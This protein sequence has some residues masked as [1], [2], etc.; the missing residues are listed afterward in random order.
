M[1]LPIGLTV[2]PLDVD[3]PAQ[4]DAAAHVEIANDLEAVGWTSET[5]DSVHANLR[6]PIA[7][8]EQHRLVHDGDSAVGVLIA[9]R[10]DSSREVFLDVAAIGPM[11]NDIQR[12]LLEEAIGGRSA[13]GGRG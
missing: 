1:A 6:S 8:R 13:V 4:V 11:A 2:S 5:R 7:W 9:E 10:V 12:A 3:D